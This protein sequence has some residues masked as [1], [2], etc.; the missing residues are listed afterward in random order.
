MSVIDEVTVGEI[1]YVGCS[2]SLASA[3]TIPSIAFIITLFTEGFAA[4]VAIFSS[5]LFFLNFTLIFCP[6]IGLFLSIGTLNWNP[7]LRWTSVT[8]LAM[9]LN[10]VMANLAMDLSMKLDPERFQDDRHLK[11]LLEERRPKIREGE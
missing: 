1:I 7:L 2:I 6:L 9:S 4:G 3:V 5:A 10:Y 8:I 11:E